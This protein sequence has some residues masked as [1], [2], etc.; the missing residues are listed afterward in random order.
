MRCTREAQAELTL[1]GYTSHWAGQ[2]MS[3]AL[4]LVF[5]FAVVCGLVMAVGFSWKQAVLLAAFA[6][7]VER[8]LEM[9]ATKPRYT[10]EPY[11]VSIIPDWEQI[12]A[13]Y[14]IVER[15]SEEWKKFKTWSEDKAL[16][17]GWY[18]V[19]RNDKDG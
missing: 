14:G 2:R 15:T 7:Y 11:Y 1:R 13:D 3:K 6:A 8:G 19:L 10:F 12:L 16:P 18:S 17:L 5:V 4:S 9:A